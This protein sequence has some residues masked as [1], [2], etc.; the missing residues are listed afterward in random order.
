MLR[1]NRVHR[2]PRKRVRVRRP[3]EASDSRAPVVYIY[4][5]TPFYN[6]ILIYYK[7]WPPTTAIKNTLICMFAYTKIRGP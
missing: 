7:N 5:H 3:F 4:I 1:Y 2:R 6:S